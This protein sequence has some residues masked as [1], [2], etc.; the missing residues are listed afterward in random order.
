MNKKKRKFDGV[1]EQA[2]HRVHWDLGGYRNSDTQN[3][4]RFGGRRGGGRDGNNGGGG[5]GRGGNGS[6]TYPPP[7]NTDRKL[8]AEDRTD[9]KEVGRRRW[10]NGSRGMGK[11]L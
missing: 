11:P 3:G 8:G 2:S 1:G 6:N 4:A 9:A 7:T 5:G 10:D